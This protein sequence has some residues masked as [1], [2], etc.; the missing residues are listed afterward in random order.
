MNGQTAEEDFSSFSI[1]DRLQHKSWK[2]RVS[3]YEELAQSFHKP[4]Q[5]SDFDTFEPHLKKMVTDANAVAQEVALT[6]ILEYVANAPHAF[7][8]R[9][10]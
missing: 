2:A 4:L 7:K 10:T 9:S 8:S 5:N 1:I 6:A 3:A